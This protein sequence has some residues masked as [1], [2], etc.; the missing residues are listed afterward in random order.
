MLLLNNLQNPEI[1]H[2]NT[3]PHRSY[4]IPFEVPAKQVS[5]IDVSNFPQSRKKSAYFTL[6]SQCEWGFSY[7]DNVQQLP[8]NFLQLPA[9]DTIF[10]PSNWQNSGYDYHQ[11]T[12]TNYPFPFDPPYVPV[13]NPCGLYQ[14]EFEMDLHTDKHYLINFEGVDSCFYLYLN[15]NFVGYSQVS[16]ATSEF[17]ITEFLNAGNNKLSVVV[18]KWCDGSYLEDQDKFRMSGIFRDVY[19]LEREKNYLQDFFVHTDLSGDLTSAT[20]NVKTDFID[21]P[22]VIHYQLFNPQGVLIAEQHASDLSVVLDN[23]QLWNAE[24]P[25]L[26]YLT[27]SYGSECIEQAIGFRKVSIEDGVFLFNNQP[28]KFRGVNRHDSDPKTGYAIS[29]E[30][31]LKDL[32]LMKQHNINAIRTAH[33]PNSPWFTELCDKYGFYVIS[34]SDIES[35]GGATL[36]VPQPETNI[37]LNIDNENW[38][39]Q[40]QQNTIDNFCYFARDPSYQK[41]ILDRTYANV[42]RDKNRTSVIIWSLGNESGY[43]EN[44]EASAKWIKQRDSSRLVHYES[45]I[46]QHSEHQND[47]SNIDLYSEMYGSTEAIEAYFSHSKTNAQTKPFL[48]CEYSHAMGNSNGDL[49]DYFQTFHKYNGACGGFVWEWCD[50]ACELTDGSGRLGYGGD[51]GEQWHDGNFCVDGLVSPDRVPHS[52]L[53]ELKNV[54]RPVRAILKDN[55]VVLENYL[56]FTNLSEINIVYK[57]LENGNVIKQGELSL[58]CE[59]HKTVELPIALPENN[60]DLWLLELAYYNKK[61]TALLEKNHLLGFEQLQLFDTSYM[62][63]PDSNLP[64]AS[65]FIISETSV[66]VVVKNDTVYCEI[67]KNKGIISVLQYNDK[68]VV[69]QPIAFNIWRAPTDNDRLMREMWQNFGY[70]DVVTRAYE[71][72]ISSFSD[73]VVVQVQGAMVTTARARILT[74]TAQYHIYANHIELEV[75][76]EKS[77]QA[78]FLPRFGLVLSL[79]KSEDNVEY[80]GYGPGESYIDKHCATKLGHYRTTVSDNHTDYLKPQENG[81]HYGT[82]YVRTENLLVTANHPFSFNFSPYTLDEL[83]V[84]THGYDLQRS[85]YNQLYIDYK[86]SGIGSNSCGP[87]LKKRYQFNELC[88]TWCCKMYFV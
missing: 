77:S 4:F 40:I 31:A 62:V 83:T 19:I 87:S 43:G 41:A 80:F 88:F 68:P 23:V 34:E 49:E 76:V 44:F 75:S 53:L 42:E 55:I 9:K 60:G 39:K 20:L 64:I 46:Y 48:L 2:I 58:S 12:N 63:Q 28:I 65:N 54:N 59:P 38:D 50:H 17:D 85:P 7:F 57:L 61:A 73:K 1:L 37:F 45:S 84:K 32:I 33:Y 72:C 22:Q 52:N 51:F 14:Y 47:L 24:N 36:P 74:F 18:F 8:G 67:D 69:H 5:H 71:T 11:Y 70:H 35:H 3:T 79:D 82:H 21:E 26:Y 66:S 16:H 56:D 15:E 10:V 29:Y 78:P 81:S 13:D 6:L 27:M 25:V 86:M 30:Q